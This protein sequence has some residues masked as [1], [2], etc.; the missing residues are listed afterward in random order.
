MPNTNPNYH[1]EALQLAEHNLRVIPIRPGLKHPGIDSWQ[2]HATTNTDTINNWWTGIYRDH[3]I[4][5][6]TGE[7]LIV[8]DIDTHGANGY[9][10]LHDLEH[11]HHKLP[12]TV[13]ARTGSGGQHLYYVS[14]ARIRNN[15]GTRLGPGID[16]RGEGGQVLAPPTKHPNGTHYQW[17][18]GRAP[19]QHDIADL[20]L[21]LEQLLTTTPTTTPPT[22]KIR[23]PFLT[24]TDSIFDTYNHTVTW[25]TLLT[26]D[27]WTPTH[28][29]AQG[30]TY[31][32]RPGKNPHEGSSATTGWN[33]LDILRVFTTSIPWLPEGTY[34]KTGYTTHR[35]HN[36]DF[37][38]FRATL[39][40]TNPLTAPTPPTT[41][42]PPSEAL[43]T[44]LNP[45]HDNPD[46]EP[47]RSSWEPHNLTD[48]FAGTAET[49]NP[50]ILHKGPQ[51]LGDAFLYPS[52]LNM[53]FG[54]SSSGKSWIALHACLEQIRNGHHVIYVDMEDHPTTIVH[55][56]K[57]LGATPQQGQNFHY[58]RPETP[59]TEEAH[60][61]ITQIINT[62]NPTLIVLDSYGEALALFGIDQNDDKG[63][64]H[65]VQ[66]I[67]RPWTRQG[68]AVLILDHVTKNTE[69]PRN[70]SIGSQR[71][72]ASI[73]GAAY[74]AT[75]TMPFTRDL[76]GLITL[77]C[78]KDR[79]GKW[80]IG[81]EIAVITVTTTHQPDTVTLT[82][83]DP[84]KKPKTPNKNEQLLIDYLTTQPN[85]ASYRQISQNGPIKNHDSIVA[86]CQS[87]H[88]QG[89]IYNASTTPGQ[90]NW[91]LT[92]HQPNPL[93]TPTDDIF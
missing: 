57:L 27:G 82:I 86:A 93:T 4:G 67:L 9:Q 19:W 24:E 16:I 77:T 35:H 26:R 87:L 30:I 20:P 64:A 56:L 33:G 92:T 66:A 14:W 34:S 41:P 89:R 12:D 58:I 15:A 44:A 21:W 52:R 53:I 85:G 75:Q 28:I 18:D 8:I 76:D 60:H 62:H 40:P 78:S 45:T 50:T 42:K 90:T 83:L 88:N 22:P 51:E 3:G 7:G 11:T 5:I 54:E 37:K 43:Q 38:A 72:R 25:E 32:S 6:A 23:D 91:R 74:R 10:T 81:H 39:A 73:D 71:K 49:L 48:H 1:Q 70:Y 47:E 68:P 17:A 59:N 55:R 69:G 63:V 79:G 2:H 46:T 65:F 29:D 36:G 84:D 13:T 80:P 31:W 61:H